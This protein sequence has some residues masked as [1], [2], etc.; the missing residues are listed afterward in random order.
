MT[1]EHKE[2]MIDAAVDFVALDMRPLN[3]LNGIGLHSLLMNYGVLWKHYGTTGASPPNL[4]P[5]VDAVSNK[6]K[7]RA[8]NLRLTLTNVLNNQFSNVGGAILLDIWTD[9]YR[10]IDY[11][12]ITVHYINDSFEHNVRIIACTALSIEKRKTGEYLR[13]KITHV[14]NFYGINLSKNVVFVTDRGSNVKKALEDYPRQNCANHFI[15][16]TVNEGLSTVRAKVVLSVCQNIVST[17][18]RNGKSSLF[19]PSLKAAFKIRWNSAT[20]MFESVSFHWQRIQQYLSASGQANILEDVTKEEIDALI[21]FLKPF[22][23][24]SLKLEQI[25]RPTQHL[26]HMVY[27]YLDA[28]LV[29]NE[30]DPQI[31]ADTKAR[32]EFYYRNAILNGGM[33]TTVNKIAIYLHPSMKNLNKMTP[34]DKE[35]INLNVRKSTCH[36]ITT[37]YLFYHLVIFCFTFS[38][39]KLLLIKLYWNRKPKWIHLR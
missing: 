27:S 2:M 32:S 15:S 16:N 14:L 34:Q 19:K 10:K 3:A 6:I 8:R 21:D 29:S 26:V 25:N 4:L 11:L 33:I 23:A 12:G 7:K 9:D 24:M 28:H 38:S 20:D 30:N 37:F 5:G 39:S 1:K 18:K 35:D 22:K 31:M 13:K 17:V 36:Y